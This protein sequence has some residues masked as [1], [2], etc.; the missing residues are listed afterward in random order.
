MET[1]PPTSSLIE[2]NVSCSLASSQEA[3]LLGLKFQIQ[4]YPKLM[5]GIE[6]WCKSRYP[7]NIAESKLGKSRVEEGRGKEEERE[8]F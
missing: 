5:K 8:T 6:F 2:G 7:I 4:G 3:L 1:A